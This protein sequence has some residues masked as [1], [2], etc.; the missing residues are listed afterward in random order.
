MRKPTFR[1][2]KKA[3]E[4]AKAEGKEAF[5]VGEYEFYTEYAK[6]VIEYLD[7]RKVDDKMLLE[8]IINNLDEQ[9]GKTIDI[10]FIIPKE[11]KEKAEKEGWKIEKD[12]WRCPNGHKNISVLANYLCIVFKIWCED[13][14]AEV[15][16]EEQIKKLM[17][18]I[19]GGVA[20]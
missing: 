4:K 17:E 18:D 10:V 1:D 7:S 13:C 11:L 8:D 2:L 14:D 16:D 20:S 6:Y 12:G 5:K 19:G 9:K 15:E 3:Y